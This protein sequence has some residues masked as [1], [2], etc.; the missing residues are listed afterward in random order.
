MCWEV[1]RQVWTHDYRG[2][3]SVALNLMSSAAVDLFLQIT[4]E[5]RDAGRNLTCMAYDR[6]GFIWSGHADGSVQLWSVQGANA[7]GSPAR[8]ADA[9]ITAIAVDSDTG[10]CW[11]GTEEGEVFILR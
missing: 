7:A 3:W 8:I 4:T 10:F 5:L 2:P 1:C 11:A 9:R 6:A